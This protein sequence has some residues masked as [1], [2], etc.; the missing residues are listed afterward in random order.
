MTHNQ[1][2]NHLRE[3]AICYTT[4]W[5]EIVR[6]HRIGVRAAQQMLSNRLKVFNMAGPGANGATAGAGR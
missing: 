4:A 2:Y 3:C 6:V 5:M 1:Q